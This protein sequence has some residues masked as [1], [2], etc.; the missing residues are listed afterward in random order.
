[1]KCELSIVN[2]HAAV[3]TQLRYALANVVWVGYGSRQLYR[4][5]VS[6]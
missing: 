2:L 6:E 1:M 5:L 4:T 3:I